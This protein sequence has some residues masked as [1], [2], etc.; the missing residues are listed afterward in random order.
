MSGSGAWA[1]FIFWLFA[2]VSVVPALMILVGKDIVRQA[3]WLLLGLSGFAGLYLS[4]GADF[5]GFT[6]VIVYIGGILVLFL[7]GVMLT[8]KGDVPVLEK[9]RGSAWGRVLP[10]VLAGLLVAGVLLW[11]VLGTPWKEAARPSGPTVAAIG[12]K[13]LT[14]F[15]LPFEVVSVLLLVALVGATYIARRKGERE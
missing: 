4:L 5:L 8:R 3:F 6:Q 10:G 7:F 9:G 14:T 1:Q 12:G 13:V 11:L 15:V 2:A